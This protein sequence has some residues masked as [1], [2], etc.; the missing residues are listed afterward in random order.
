MKTKLNTKQLNKKLLLFTGIGI[1]FIILIAIGS[2]LLTLLKGSHQSYSEVEST[3]IKAATKYYSK[4]KEL[5]PENNGG[6]VVVDVEDLIKEDYMK[7]LNKLLKNG[8]SCQ[9]EV[10]VTKNDNYYY[11]APTL[12]C[13][14]EYITTTLS[15]KITEEKN[16][17][18]E[19]DGLYLIG[20]DFVFRGEKV[21]NNLSF[22]GQTWR[23]LRV[24]EDGTIR[25][26]LTSRIPKV[27]WDDRYNE[28]KKTNSGINDFK[29][30]RI[31]DSIKELYSGKDLFN[32]SD[33]AK[34][35]PQDLC[36]GKR[37]I[38]DTQNDG[39]IECAEIMENQ[40]VGLLQANEFLLASL[41]SACES[42]D[43]RQCQNYNYLANI[44]ETYWSIT[45][46]IETSHKAYKIGKNIT[47]STTASNARPFITI[48]L[49]SGIRYVSG[50][51]SAE[52]PYIVK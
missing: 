40:A 3:M 1:G 22:A 50:D 26:L 38:Y 31:Y 44:N 4:N 34:I 11:Y 14:K 27:L 43:N 36:V 35:V 7:E 32:D 9:G 12:D 41:D 48:H 29:L 15:D 16:I 52:T 23:I 37:G 46:D 49:N 19:G 18:T 17:V 20:N 24:K 30:S 21:N 6:M 51:G 13:G 47:P 5:L 8:E 45:A 39:S 42:I 10:I 25:L 33:R 2:L 28:E